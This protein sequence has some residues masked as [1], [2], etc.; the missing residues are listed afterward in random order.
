MQITQYCEKGYC[1][2][3][4]D[5]ETEGT[6]GSK[7]KRSENQLGKRE[8]KKPSCWL[9]DKGGYGKWKGCDGNF[10]CAGHAEDL[11][12]VWKAKGR[13]RLSLLWLWCVKV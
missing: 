3:E 5:P 2:K 4:C 6:E 11:Q 9:A 10:S 8:E 7:K 12:L 13:T 1:Q